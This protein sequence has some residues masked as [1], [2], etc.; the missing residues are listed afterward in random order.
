MSSLT[1]LRSIQSGGCEYL[2]GVIVPGS[3]RNLKFLGGCGGLKRFRGRRDSI[4]CP[5]H[6][7]RPVVSGA[8]LLC[9]MFSAFK[10]ERERRASGFLP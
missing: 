7:S 9:G 6:K 5:D 4:C 3:A 1:F 2:K 8:R 10:C